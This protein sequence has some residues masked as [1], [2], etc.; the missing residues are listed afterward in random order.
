MPTVAAATPPEHEIRL[1]DEKVEPV[2]LEDPDPP[3]LVGITLHT[4]AA[5]RA[6]ELAR[7]FRRL[8]AFTVLGGPHA[9]ARPSEG[10]QH[11]DA[12]VVGDCEDTWPRLIADLEAGT[13]RRI[14]HSAFPPLTDVTP[15]RLDLLGRDAYPTLAVTHATRGCPYRCEFCN[16]PGLSGGQ[17]RQR[18]VRNVVEEVEALRGP[19]VVFWDDNLTADRKYALK[20][21]EE[22]RPLR[23][24]WIGQA[25]VDLI[26]RPELV[27]AAAASGCIGLFIGF[28][29]FSVESLREVRKLHNRVEQYR[30][31]MKLVHD[32]GIVIDAG[33]MFGFDHDTPD[34]FDATL[35]ASAEIGLDIVNFNILTPFPGTPLFERYL[36][37]GRLLT[38]DWD[39]YQPTRSVVHRPARMTARELLDGYHDVLERFYRWGP[40]VARTLR[41]PNRGKHLTWFLNRH[42]RKVSRHILDHR[43]PLPESTEPGGTPALAQRG[44]PLV[45]DLDPVKAGSPEE[46]SP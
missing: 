13:P 21:F 9:S 46:T 3:E 29:S 7:S 33:V 43:S 30:D 40:L 4:G 27:E 25:T 31:V 28:E 16:V 18:P 41:S 39:R 37:D 2:P 36:T 8:G 38:L 22:L 5:T 12:V 35:E 44:H 42:F 32:H 34:V 26:R 19:L 23:R 6:Y 20:L 15:A 1:I 14:Y 11:A 24:R 45:P 17:Y 10:L